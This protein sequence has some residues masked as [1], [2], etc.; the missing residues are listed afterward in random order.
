M[1]LLQQTWSA[2]AP[3][4]EERLAEGMP[5]TLAAIADG[6]RCQ[7][8]CDLCA[9]AEGGRHVMGCSTP[10]CYHLATNS[11][12]ILLQSPLYICGLSL[13][14]TKSSKYFLCYSNCI[15]I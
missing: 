5:L 2:F 1:A 4:Q 7:C 13:H 9:K 8:H 10:S 3:S 14:N 11:D 12:T 15:I 6:R